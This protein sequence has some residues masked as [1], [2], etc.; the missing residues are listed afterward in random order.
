MPLTLESLQVVDAIARRGSFAAAAAEL[1]RVPSA[2]TYSVR[3]LEGDLDVLLFD[4]RGRRAVLTAAGRELLDQGRNLL[5]AADDLACRVRRVASGWEVELRIALDAIVSFDRVTPLIADFHAQGA[6]TRLRLLHEVM[7]GG[8]DALA[9]GRADLAIGAPGDAPMAMFAPG[10][11]GVR[12]LGHVPFVFCVAPHHPLASAV[13]P[14]AAG[15]VLRHRAVVL[16]DTA[17]VLPLGTA[18]LLAGQDTL[19]VGTLGQKL[20]AQV[21]GLGCGWLPEPFARAPLAAGR[22]VAREVAEPRP[23]V[24]T[25]YAWRKAGVGNALRW[26]LDRLA[27]ARVRQLLLDGPHPSGGA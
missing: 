11:F 21:A 10:A 15:D 5:R 23:P 17:R 14:L 9:S 12:E 13:A 4:R 25:R 8:W 27:L 2:I 19:T 1:G 22:L 3:Q 24:Q 6:P 7:G 18:G 20:A 16:G 26:W